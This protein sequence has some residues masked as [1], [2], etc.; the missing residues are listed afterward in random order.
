MLTGCGNREKQELSYVVKKII[1]AGI[2][3]NYNCISLNQDNLYINSYMLDQSTNELQAKLYSVDS[4][5]KESH[6]IPVN[7]TEYGYIL[8]MNALSDQKI[9]LVIKE[10]DSAGE[11]MDTLLALVD[12]DGNVKEKIIA[13]EM[14]D[15]GEHFVR[16]LVAKD[17]SV[18]LV[19]NKRLYC[20]NVNLKI[21]N[22][23]DAAEEIETAGFTK[24]EKIVCISPA[25]YDD[26]KS[27]MLVNTYE[28]N[29]GWEKSYLDLVRGNGKIQ[30]IDGKDYDYYFQNDIGI[31]G[32]GKK[33]DFLLDFRKVNISMNDVN[34]SNGILALEN[35]EFLMIGY[36]TDHGDSYLAKF[37]QGNPD[38]K[39]TLVLGGINI[40]DDVKEQVYAFNKKNPGYEIMIRDY[41]ADNANVPM[42]DIINRLNADLIK[43]Q[44]IDIVFLDG[45]PVK[46][47]AKKGILLKLDDYING[48]PEISESDFVPSLA[49]AMKIDGGL[50]FI[51]P[52]FTPYA[53]LV[54]KSIAEE[55]GDFSIKNLYDK[56]ESNQ[57]PALLSLPPTFALEMIAPY[58][59]DEKEIK[60]EDLKMLL[61]M[62]STSQFYSTDLAN[63][64]EENK[65]WFQMTYY[66]IPYEL[67]ASHVLFNDQMI[68]VGLPG[69]E[70][71]AVYAQFVNEIGIVAASENRDIAYQFISELVAEDKQEDGIMVLYYPTTKAGVD[72]MIENFKEGQTLS[73][74][75][76]KGTAWENGGITGQYEVFTDE[77]CEMVQ[78]MINSVKYAWYN[79]SQQ[80]KL[81]AEEAGAYFGGDKDLDKVVESMKNRLGLYSQE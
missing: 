16:L 72:H 67:Q 63:A 71:S 23:I 32:I 5:F 70:G 10:M 78:N 8:Q 29:K 75:S 76:M 18:I 47:Y 46:D 77:E 73:G 80:T 62:C 53:L 20:L 27:R 57:K 43:G 36:N 49:E 7:I 21:E 44:E 4:S 64:F 81:I 31:Y 22:T 12:Q 60:D 26:I 51:A 14:F 48:D 69:S 42:D 35:S 15:N 56:W 1:P 33:N 74:T 55:I 17:D 30:I 19:S 24:E 65:I 61:E 79:D 52:S 28:M 66:R 41:A 11:Y 37:V 39:E 38:E 2:E 25:K 58:L 9:L 13:D 45:L 3:G 40:G 50:Y 68:T 34:Q 54:K 6:E 59:L